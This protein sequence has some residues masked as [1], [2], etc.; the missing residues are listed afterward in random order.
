MGKVLGLTLDIL[1]NFLVPATVPSSAATLLAENISLL[2]IEDNN[3][4]RQC[5]QEF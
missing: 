3:I 5:F 4:N 1:Q 2:E